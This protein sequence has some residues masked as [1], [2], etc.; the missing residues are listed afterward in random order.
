M[1]STSDDGRETEI[2]AD[3]LPVAPAPTQSGNTPPKKDD[4]DGSAHAEG[5]I[6]I[7]PEILR[8]VPP[9]HNLDG[10]RVEVVMVQPAQ[11]WAQRAETL[12]LSVT[13]NAIY[14]LIGVAIGL[15]VAGSAKQAESAPPENGCVTAPAPTT[16]RLEF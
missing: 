12:V 11:S 3:G 5:T 1:A 14:G 13:G 4:A 8:G 6:R 15:L 7:N 2:L 9:F 10:L 16:D